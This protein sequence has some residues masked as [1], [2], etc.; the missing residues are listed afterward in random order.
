MDDGVPMSSW[1]AMIEEYLPPV[2]KRYFPLAV[3]AFF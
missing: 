2:S 1:I 3:I